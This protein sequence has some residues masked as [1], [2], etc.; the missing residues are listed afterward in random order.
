[1]MVLS[2]SIFSGRPAEIEVI[3][4]LRLPWTRELAVFESTAA[5]DFMDGHHE[6][7]LYMSRAVWAAF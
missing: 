5:Y 4:V 3:L 2:L 1:M 6:L 7:I